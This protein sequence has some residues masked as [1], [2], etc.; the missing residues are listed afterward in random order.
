[1]KGILAVPKPDSIEVHMCGAARMCSLILKDRSGRIIVLIT[2]PCVD[3]SDSNRSS[4][5][6]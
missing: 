3:L 6:L 2:V 5:V 4:S 1:M